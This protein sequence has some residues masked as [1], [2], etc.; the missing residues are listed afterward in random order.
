MY[1]RSHPNCPAAALGAGPGKTT[2]VVA[3]V[4]GNI[5]K[6]LNPNGF[7]RELLAGAAVVELFAVFLFLWRSF[8]SI[9]NQFY[10][11]REEKFASGRKM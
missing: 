7:S 6:G 10:V 5:R 1:L 4:P 3:A 2:R 11:A 8:R 9:R